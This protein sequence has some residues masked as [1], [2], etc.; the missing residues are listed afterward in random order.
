VMNTCSALWRERGMSVS[1]TAN[2]ARSVH[3][4]FGRA[5]VWRCRTASWW[6]SRRISASFYVGGRLD[7]RSHAGIWTARRNTKR[8][9]KRRDH[10]RP[11]CLTAS[12]HPVMTWPYGVSAST[13]AVA[14]HHLHRG[15][16][17][18][19]TR[20]PPPGDRETLGPARPD[21]RGHAGP[22][23]ARSPQRTR[24]RRRLR[25]PPPAWL[26]NQLTET[27]QKRLRT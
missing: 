25:R 22:V 27:I 11:A 4:S 8:R 21:G 16:A 1:S 9:N 7:S 19:R 23:L 20:L 14:G 13:G 17:R 10:R 26:D 24:R 3:V 6:H 2:R 5:A 12:R 18:P 15:Q